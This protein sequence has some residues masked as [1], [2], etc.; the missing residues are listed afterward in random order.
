[1][2]IVSVWILIACCGVLAIAALV[3]VGFSIAAAV[4][5]GRHKDAD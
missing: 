5:T 4:S 3:R 1:M 2:G